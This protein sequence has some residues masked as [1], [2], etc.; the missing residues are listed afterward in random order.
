[1][2][3][4]SAWSL[5]AR[6]ISYSY[7][8]G[9]KK[10]KNT[11]EHKPFKFLLK[12]KSFSVFQEWMTLEFFMNPSWLLSKQRGEKKKK[13]REK[14][15]KNNKCGEVERSPHRQE[16]KGVVQREEGKKK[17]NPSV[18][19][20]RRE[21]SVTF[22]NLWNCSGGSHGW[23]GGIHGIK[24]RTTTCACLVSSSVHEKGLHLR[25]WRKFL[26]Y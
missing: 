4:Q 20:L 26:F 13:Q 25:F 2:R 3:H 8:E 21:A 9:K 7:R 22:S 11:Q 18:I 17:N 10:Q 15:D 23:G 24:S 6:N 16:F 14:S 5:N 19:A 12:L 1:M